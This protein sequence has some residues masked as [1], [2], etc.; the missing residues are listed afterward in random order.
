MKDKLRKLNLHIKINWLELAGTDRHAFCLLLQEKVTF[1][2]NCHIKRLMLNTANSVLKLIEKNCNN[3]AMLT[4][5]YFFMLT[6]A[7]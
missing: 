1:E 5:N 4:A 2:V 3:G 6:C 7:K